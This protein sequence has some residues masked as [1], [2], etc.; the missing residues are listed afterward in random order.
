MARPSALNQMF[1]TELGTI[2]RLCR[3]TEKDYKT[4]E[5]WSKESNSTWQTSRRTYCFGGE[6]APKYILLKNNVLM[7][8]R[9]EETVVQMVPPVSTDFVKQL[10]YSSYKKETELQET[11]TKDET[12]VLD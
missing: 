5:A 3:K 12:E 7:K 10:L 8:A 2:Y 9:E 1:L 6:K 11:I 4:A